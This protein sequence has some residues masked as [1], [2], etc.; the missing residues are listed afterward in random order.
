MTPSGS[1]GILIGKLPQP[2]AGGW[3]LWANAGTLA[4]PLAAEPPVAEV[5]PAEFPQPAP[6]S[7]TAAAATANPARFICLFLRS[8]VVRAPYSRTEHEIKF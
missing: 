7:A 8:R 1:A 3:K 2:D 5:P 4:L 6:M